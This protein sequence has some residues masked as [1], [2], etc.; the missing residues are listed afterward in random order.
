MTPLNIGI[1]GTDSS[2]C[3]AF[4]ELLN[5]PQA[6]YH[7][8][9]G[10]VVAAFLGGSADFPLSAKRVEGFMTT[11]ETKYGIQRY[12]SLEQ[13]A[14][15]CDAILLTSADGRVHLEQ[16]KAIAPYGKPVFIDK[17]LALSYET[18]QQI[19]VIAKQHG[20]PLMSSSALRYAEQLTSELQHEHAAEVTGADITGPLVV[21]PTQSYY[22]WYGIHAVEMLYAIMGSG[23][24]EV[25]VTTAEAYAEEDA[26]EDAAE[27]CGV[28]KY[29][30]ISAKW[31]D[32]RLA[33][34][35]LS[36]QPETG[37][38]A[39][40]YR[41]ESTSGIEINS[42]AKPFYASLLEQIMELFYTRSSPL[43]WRETLEVIRF[44]EAAEQSRALKRSVFM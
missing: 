42:Q 9:G 16:F 28:E 18:A 30:L 26:A 38:G 22:Y 20:I 11:L 32:G 12:S 8:P 23:C 19:F 4:T 33:T 29:D 25:N 2:H 35:K 15:A 13:V 40:V 5:N 17:P 7:V 27:E 6:E 36:R 1:I 21:E 24:L 31:K 34:V 3:M 14:A 44:V 37:F 43:D 10:K 39:K 41:A